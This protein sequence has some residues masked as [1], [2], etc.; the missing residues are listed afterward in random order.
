MRSLLA[1]WLLSIGQKSAKTVLAILDCQEAHSNAVA[2]GIKRCSQ[3]APALYLIGAAATLR[4]RFPNT[5]DEVQMLQNWMTVLLPVICWGASGTA[6]DATTRRLLAGMRRW[7]KLPIMR[8]LIVCLGCTPGT[9]NMMRRRQ[10]LD[11]SQAVELEPENA[12]FR[13]ELDYLSKLT[14]ACS[15]AITSSG[16]EQSG[17][18]EAG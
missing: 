16:G 5:L 15:R 6:K 1:G 7:K 18:P 4:V 8:Q 12:R 2:R 9:N 10:W 11:S 14:G 13:F 3:R 17:R